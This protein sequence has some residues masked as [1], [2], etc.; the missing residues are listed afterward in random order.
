MP[1]ADVQIRITG[2][3]RQVGSLAN[4]VK[5]LEGRTRR[6]RIDVGSGRIVGP[7]NVDTVGNVHAGQTAYDTGTGFWIEYNGG[8]P[9]LSIGNSAGNKLLF[10]GTNVS[11]VGSVTATSG[12][13]GGWTIGATT[14]TGGNVTLDAAG[15]ISV[16][17]AAGLT[18]ARIDNNGNAEFNNITARGAINTAVLVYNQVHATGGS[19]ILSKAAF[20]L[21]TAFTTVNS[22]TTFNV[23]TEDA[24]GSTHAASQ[25]AIAGD[26]LRLKDGTADA[27]L[28][29]SSVSDQ[30]TFWRYVCTKSSPAAG[31]NYTFQA[32]AAIVN[33]GQTGQGFLY[34]TA[35]DA[36]GPFYSVRTH[37]GSPWS[38]ATER[39]RLGNLKNAY[40]VGANNRY[41]I[42]LG[43][44]S[45]GNYMMYNPTDSFV[46]KVGGGEVL[47]GATGISL[48]TGSAVANSIT[49]VNGATVI[50]KE[51]VVDTT[52]TNHS[53]QTMPSGVG[54]ITT[55]IWQAEV[56]NNA[57]TG[58]TILRVDAGATPHI[59]LTDSGVSTFAGVIIGD[60]ILGTNP[61]AMLDVRG[62]GIFTGGLN[63]G[64]A[65]GATAGQIILSD[66]LLPSADA[67]KNIGST[68]K[69]ISVG[70][71]NA[72]LLGTSTG[73][74]AGGITMTGN[75]TIT[76]SDIVLSTTTGTKIGTATTQKLGF[77]NATPIV[78]GTAFTQTYSTPSTVHNNPVAVAPSAY[79]TGAFGYSTGTKAQE[80]R[81][82]AANA[83]ADIADIKMVLNG[84]IDQLQA[85]GLLA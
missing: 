3:E 48:K 15:V 29:V 19:M 17:Y 72:L 85:L 76:D 10:D 5:A 75:L 58:E 77:F 26:I 57:L 65:T 73:V 18:G 9:R 42:G 74:G 33:Y 56:F 49:F 25:L 63:V 27:W 68:T 47:I 22:P 82:C 43:D 51:F 80:V 53:T 50:G 52:I 30:T 61:N 23:D 37:A 44:F 20:K 32:G 60:G 70:H 39:L 35:D 46:I 66:A 78:R 4:Q 69:R 84:V 40:G 64:T 7:V 14:L 13:I 79:V 6:N 67:T 11:I 38:A 12:N 21:R 1:D 71:F 62:S 34:L 55:A 2:L 54:G 28:T 31:T 16:N 45:G 24:E 41:G 83:V 81:D 59:E 8:T 36:D